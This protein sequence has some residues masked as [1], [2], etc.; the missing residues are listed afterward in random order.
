MTPTANSDTIKK[1]YRLPTH[2]GDYPSLKEITPHSRR[3][4]LSL[5]IPG[6]HTNVVTWDHVGH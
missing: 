3:K 4:S 1:G 2:Q 5:S 6:S